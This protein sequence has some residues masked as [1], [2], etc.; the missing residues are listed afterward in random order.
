M[1]VKFEVRG[2]EQVE[3][4]LNEV[5]RG[6]KRIAVQAVTDYMIG[7]ER[8]GLK[9]YPPVKTQKYVRTFTLRQG[10][11]RSGDEYKPVIRNYVPYAPYVPRWKKYGWR[12]WGKVIA[13]NMDGAMRHAQ[14]LVNKYLEQWK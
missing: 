11:L 1:N 3:K 7:D 4:M 12:E 2:L 8:H 6:T 14:S 10:W 5:P 13:D 9:Y